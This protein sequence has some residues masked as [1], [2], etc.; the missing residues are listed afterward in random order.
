MFK[1]KTKRASRSGVYVQAKAHE[2]MLVAE[3]LGAR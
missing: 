3:L 1:R 2:A